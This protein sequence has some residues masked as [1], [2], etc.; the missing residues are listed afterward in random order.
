L[1]SW[2]S[3]IISDSSKAVNDAWM[4]EDARN[5]SALQA[6]VVNIGVIVPSSRKQV[7]NMEIKEV[8]PVEE[9]WPDVI[10][11]SESREEYSRISEAVGELTSAILDCKL[12][13]ILTQDVARDLNGFLSIV[14]S[15]LNQIKK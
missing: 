1:W 8:K 15:V 12:K 5:A 10:G 7:L 13:D 6:K 11:E 2:E 9:E 3:R 14:T 4:K